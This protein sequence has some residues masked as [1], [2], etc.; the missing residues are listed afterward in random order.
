MRACAVKFEKKARA[1]TALA[2]ATI[3]VDMGAAGTDV[4]M[5]T[6][7]IVLMSDNQRNIPFAIALSKPSRRVVTQNLAFALASSSCWS[8]ARCGL[9]CRCL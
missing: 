1:I 9:R 8:A 4:A 5:E 6:A 2:N 7:D 3:G